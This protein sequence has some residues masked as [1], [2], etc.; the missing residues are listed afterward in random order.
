MTSHHKKHKN[1]FYDTS[2][3]TSVQRMI[4]I[5]SE[6]VALKSKHLFIFTSKFWNMQD[7]T[8]P[9]PHVLTPLELRDRFLANMLTEPF[10]VNDQICVEL[11]VWRPIN[12]IGMN[13]AHARFY[14]VL[15]FSYHFRCR[16]YHR[17]GHETFSWW[18]SLSGH[19]PRWIYYRH[20]SFMVYYCYCW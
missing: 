19:Y 10:P 13:Y 6:Y 7:T 17:V 2:E 4:F 12:R 9:H 20:A 16:H 14:K 3:H 18:E 8:A 15:I 5:I 1:S 11:G